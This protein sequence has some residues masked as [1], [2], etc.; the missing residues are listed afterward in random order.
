MKV[1]DDST[2]AS[3]L[4]KGIQSPAGGFVLTRSYMR[5]YFSAKDHQVRSEFV[6]YVH[7]PLLLRLLMFFQGLRHCIET[8]CELAQLITRFD[9]D[10]RVKPAGESGPLVPFLSS[11]T[12]ASRCRGQNERHD[13]RQNEV[14]DPKAYKCSSTAAL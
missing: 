3:F 9:G 6:R 2:F 4:V 11:L 7:Q 10:S 1:A 5:L 12:G 8:G 13:E 14:T